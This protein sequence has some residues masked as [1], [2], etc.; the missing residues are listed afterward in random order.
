MGKMDKTQAKLTFDQHRS[1]KPQEE[2]LEHSFPAT[3]ETDTEVEPDIKK[4]LAAMQHSLAKIDGKIDA[5][6][7][8]MGRMNERLDKHAEC[9]DAMEHRISDLE[10]DH[11]ATSTS[12]SQMDKTLAAFHAK[13]EDLEARS[14]R[15][16]LRIVG[17]A[18]STAIDNMEM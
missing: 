3:C 17:I 12:Q 15:N 7:F 5:L 11:T 2:R 18:E 13:V 9:I 1:Y 6:S 16:N 10:D 4:I 8:Q 14:H